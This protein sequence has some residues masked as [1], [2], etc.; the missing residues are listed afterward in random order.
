MK[1]EIKSDV[2]MQVSFRLLKNMKGGVIDIYYFSGTRYEHE[3]SWTGKGSGNIHFVVTND[4]GE[5]VGDIV[6]DAENDDE[7]ELINGGIHHSRNKETDKFLM[8]PYE[9]ERGDQN[10]FQ[11]KRNF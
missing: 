9:M 7:A 4:Q 10:T 8:I 5:D 3:A 1:I 2:Q 6:L 11:Y